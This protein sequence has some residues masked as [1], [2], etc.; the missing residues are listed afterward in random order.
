ME[1][2]NREVVKMLDMQ[3]YENKKGIEFKRE[4]DL[5]AGQEMCKQDMLT[6]AKERQLLAFK[7]D[8]IKNEMRAAWR[9]QQAYKDSLNKVQTLF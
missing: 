5:K 1:K 6:Q 4:T 8:T 3:V 7:R 2:Q 9:E